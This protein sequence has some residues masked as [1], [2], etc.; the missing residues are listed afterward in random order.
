MIAPFVCKATGNRSIA[1][2]ASI[3]S[4]LFKFPF[5]DVL[6]VDNAI[7]IQIEINVF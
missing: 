5:L 7:S 1:Q 2:R 6:T 4:D 3:V